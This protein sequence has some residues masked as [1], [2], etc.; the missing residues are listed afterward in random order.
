[1]VFTQLFTFGY[2]P[3]YQ[4]GYCPFRFEFSENFADLPVGKT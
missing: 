4:Q 3:F 1:M 2:L